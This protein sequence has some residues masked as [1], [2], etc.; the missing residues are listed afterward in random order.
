MDQ[1]KKEEK[2]LAQQLA[3]EKV[4]SKLKAKDFM[5]PKTIS[6]HP[7]AT[8]KETL[9]RMKESNVSSLPVV[10]KGGKVVGIISDYD[11]LLLIAGKN[12]DEKISYKKDLISLTAE[13]SIKEILVTFVRYKLKK[14][15]I[16]DAFQKLLGMIS[17]QEFI[18][19]LLETKM[20][21]ENKKKAA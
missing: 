6:I 17:R 10:E 12:L 21:D 15:P 3:K 18:F 19:K 7:E 11:I 1:N 8:I 5:D 13:S 16:V 20:K 2:E 9:L 14:I 4:V